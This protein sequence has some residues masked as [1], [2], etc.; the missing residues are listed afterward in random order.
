MG[1]LP[2][3]SSLPSSRCQGLAVDAPQLR[4]RLRGAQPAHSGCASSTR[5]HSGAG[6]SG[7]AS[8]NSKGPALEHGGR[9]CVSCRPPRRISRHRGRRRNGVPRQHAHR[10][11]CVAAAEAK[12]GEEE[13]RDGDENAHVGS[14]RGGPQKLDHTIHK[15]SPAS[16]A[17]LSPIFPGWF[18]YSNLEILVQGLPWRRAA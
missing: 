7:S 10:S 9:S 13:S 2:P 11:V 14:P 4:C 6:R 1:C 16:G 3:R 18:P 12:P 17:R 5:Q 8:R 15:S